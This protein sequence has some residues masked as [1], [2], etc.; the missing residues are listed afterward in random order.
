[1]RELGPSG[2]RGGER[3]LPLD[4]PEGG[5]IDMVDVEIPENSRTGK[6][7]EAGGGALYQIKLSRPRVNE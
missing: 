6:T 4:G 1:M 2:L 7:A 5:G 3:A